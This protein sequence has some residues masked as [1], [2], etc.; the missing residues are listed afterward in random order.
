[1]VPKLTVFIPWCPV[2]AVLHARIMQG[3][4][5]AKMV[6][7]RTA[8]KATRDIPWYPFEHTVMP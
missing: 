4:G 5:L 7:P 1:M 2:A 3:V 6:V 8:G